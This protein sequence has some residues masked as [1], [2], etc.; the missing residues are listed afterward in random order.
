MPNIEDFIKKGK[1]VTIKSNEIKLELQ[2]PLDSVRFSSEL[3]GIEQVISSLERRIQDSSF[4]FNFRYINTLNG[5]LKRTEEHNLEMDLEI[6][7]KLDRL[8]DID[9][10]L[11]V[12]RND[13]LFRLKIKDSLLIPKYTE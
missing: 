1:F 6:Q 2:K 8:S 7:E 4:Q 10:L 11:S 5:I 9:S 3:E 13:D 12:F